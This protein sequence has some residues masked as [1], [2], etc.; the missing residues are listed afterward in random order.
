MVSLPDQIGQLRTHFIRELQEAASAKELEEIKVKY[1]GKKGPVQALMMALKDCS[2]DER[3][4]M[5]K[6]INDLKDELVSHCEGSLA[7]LKNQEMA[8]AFQK[9]WIDATL[10]GRRHA[11]GRV[12]PITQMMQRVIDILTGMGFSVQLGPDVDTDY[13]NFEGLNFAPDHPARDMQDTF[14]LGNTFLLRTHTSNTQV[15]AME[16][17]SPPL[18]IAAPGRAFRNEDVSA[19]SHV[20]F[21][22]LEAFYVD[23][24]VSFADLLSTMDEFLKK[25][26]SEKVKTRFRPSYFPFVEPGMEVDVSCTACSGKGCRI[27]KHTGWLEILG[28]GMIHPNVMRNGKIDPEEYSG[29]AWGMGIERPAMLYFDIPDIRLF[30]ENDLRFLSQFS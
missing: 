9:E 3:P 10:P 1:L 4:H 15:H 5:G 19:R 13:Y 30:T 23:K 8:A 17:F 6:L 26:L 24:G 7:R 18:R 16:K 20:F 11:L 27:C 28:A 12:H 29:F 14:Y 22:Q 25:L 21:H 2:A